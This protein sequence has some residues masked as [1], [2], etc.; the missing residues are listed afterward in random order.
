MT[1]MTE[2]DIVRFNE[3]GEHILDLMNDSGLSSAARMTI[4]FGLLRSMLR[5][6]G[7]ERRRPVADW[8]LRS[9]Q[10]IVEEAMTSGGRH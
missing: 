5:G 1:M 6:M 8:V 4:V 7:P 3:L 10:A 9:T 2:E